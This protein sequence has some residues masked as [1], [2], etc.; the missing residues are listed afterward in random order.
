MQRNYNAENRFSILQ[1]VFVSQGFKVEQL[2]R[3]KGMRL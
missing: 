2:L 3:K 1:T